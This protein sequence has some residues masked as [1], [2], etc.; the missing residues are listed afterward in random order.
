M[1]WQFNFD[2]VMLG[3]KP[4][5]PSVNSMMAD[6]GTSLNMI[7]DDDFNAI[8]DTFFKDSHCYVL[9]NSLTACDCTKEEHEAVPAITFKIEGDEYRID[10]DMWYERKDSTCVIKFMHAPGR[11]EWILG[12]N[13]FQSYYAVM[14]YSK[15]RIGFAKSINFG[16]AGSRHFIDW[17]LSGSFL[18]NLV[19]DV[20]SFAKARQ[21]THS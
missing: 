1:F 11:S 10:R 9:K 5:T 7:P 12:V 21:T 17:A 16:K 19:A 8:R 15:N 6:S 13:F 20:S 2:D 4:F 14:D 3:D 18:L